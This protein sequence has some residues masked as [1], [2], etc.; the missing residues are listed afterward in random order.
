MGFGGIR[1]EVAMALVG[2]HHELGIGNALGQDLGRHSVIDFAGHV[3]VAI[4]D[5]NERGLSDVFQSLARVVALAG[6]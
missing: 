5:E 2:Q 6:E 1:K 3:A 4:A